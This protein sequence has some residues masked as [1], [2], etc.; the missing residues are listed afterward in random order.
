[1]IYH[2][3]KSILL[4]IRVHNRL[5]L[6]KTVLGNFKELIFSGK[7]AGITQEMVAPVYRYTVVL[8]ALVT[9]FEISV[10]YFF[11]RSDVREQF[12]Q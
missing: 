4:N 1:M 10:V 7:L 12:R 9:L 11:T 3:G 8:T 5:V 2:V 6:N